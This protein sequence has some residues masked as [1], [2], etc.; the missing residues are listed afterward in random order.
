MTTRPTALTSRSCAARRANSGNRCCR[1][2]ARR[3]RFHLGGKSSAGGRRGPG[4]VSARTEMFVGRFC[5]SGFGQGQ[6]ASNRK[7]GRTSPFGFRTLIYVFCALVGWWGTIWR[8][9]TDRS[10]AQR[11]CRESTPRRRSPRASKR[12]RQRS[13]RCRRLRR[14][15]HLKQPPSRAQLLYEA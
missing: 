4:E 5:G 13:P 2:A 12:V 8:A 9:S 6:R 10:P 3:A 14:C 11:R 1:R 15:L 7:N